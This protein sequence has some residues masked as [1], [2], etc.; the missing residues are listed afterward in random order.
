MIKS[1]TTAALLSTAVFCGAVVDTT[2]AQSPVQQQQ[3]QPLPSLHL[4]LLTA[5]N[6]ERAKYN[7]SALCSNAKLQRAAQLHAEDQANNNFM[8]HTGSDGSNMQ[9]RVERQS[10]A[11]Q[12][13]AENVAAGQRDV[14]AVM[15]SWMRSNGHRRNILGKYKFF[16][17][18][19]A[20]S[21]SSRYK[22]YWTQDFATGSDEACDCDDTPTPAPD[23]PTPSPSPVP[24]PSSP[25]PEPSSSA[26]SVTPSSA[27]SP[28]DPSTSSPAPTSAPEPTTQPPTPEPTPAPVPSPTP[29]PTQAPSPPSNSL[30]QRMLEAVNAERAKLGLA[31][32]C[33]NGKLQRAAQLHSEDQANN[34]FMDH[35]GSD[36]S[37]MTDRMERQQFKWGAAA[38]NVAAGQVDIASVMES[39]MNS[40]GHRRNILGDYK[41]F[42]MGYAT[43]PSSTY[44]HYW[45]QDFGSGAEER[46][47]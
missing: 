11:W 1:L 25:V 13:L 32:F 37:S 43:N 23:T 3:Q 44:T 46:C 39:W 40:E 36:G 33:T 17:G 22:R 29:A 9:T 24:V 12:A 6:A 15:S 27:P 10:F 31:P 4:Q 28:T 18:G 38:E 14:A 16:G 26:P 5:V 2:A 41:F 21:S 7:L 45:T 47:D 35:T 8:S 34:N 42:G 19:F 30:Q 20:Q